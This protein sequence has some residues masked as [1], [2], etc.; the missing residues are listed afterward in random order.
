MP[1]ASVGPRLRYEND[2][3]RAA[4]NFRELCTR[5][6]CSTRSTGDAPDLLELG[7]PAQTTASY[8][9]PRKP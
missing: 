4:A 5:T 8:V 9:R 1:A 7:E 2:T 6:R 3:D